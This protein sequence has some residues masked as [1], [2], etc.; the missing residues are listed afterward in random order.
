VPSCPHER[1]TSLCGSSQIPRN[2]PGQKLTWHHHIFAKRKQLGLTLTKMYWLLGRS[3]RLS[4]TQQAPSL[5]IHPQTHLDLRH[6]TLGHS[7]HIQHR[8][9]RTLSIKGP[10]HNRRCTVVCAEPS[11]S[12][13]P[14]NDFRQRRNLPLKQPILHSSHHTSNCP[15]INPRGNS[16]QQAFAKTRAKRSA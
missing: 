16:R 15:N 14:P 3:S 1:A 6:P 13:G 4:L 12:S 2:P 7:I 5:Q 8:D 9:P 10:A 11:H